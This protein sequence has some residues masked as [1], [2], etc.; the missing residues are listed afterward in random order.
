MTS[1]Y[2]MTQ[3]S[4]VVLLNIS[5]IWLPLIRVKKSILKNSTIRMNLEFEQ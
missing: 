3:K 5:F 2:S 1:S 4:S